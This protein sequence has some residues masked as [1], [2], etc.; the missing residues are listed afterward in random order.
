MRNRSDEQHSHQHEV[1]NLQTMEDLMQTKE[2]LVQATST[3]SALAAAKQELVL[4]LECA[5]EEGAENAS[6]SRINPMRSP[7]G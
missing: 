1:A 3:N 5:L 6:S 4:E 7:D 2:D